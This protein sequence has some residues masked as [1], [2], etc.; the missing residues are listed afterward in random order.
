MPVFPGS[1]CGVWFLPG[2]LSAN[3]WMLPILWFPKYSHT[4]A[5]NHPTMY[6]AGHQALISQWNLAQV[7]LSCPASGVMPQ[8]AGCR[9]HIA[10]K[11]GPQLS[12]NSFDQRAIW[13]T[14]MALLLYWHSVL[15]TKIK[16]L[17]QMNIQQRSFFGPWFWS[18]R[19][20]VFTWWWPFC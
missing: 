3:W 15:V 17:K 1:R 20:Q 5:H 10:S 16:S 9:A 18:Y 11:G 8:Q 13:I 7:A 14:S 4:P 6:A 2:S 19:L 12:H